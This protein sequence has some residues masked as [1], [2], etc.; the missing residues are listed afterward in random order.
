MLTHK[1]EQNLKTAA[2]IEE[3]RWKL[4]AMLQ[5]RTH[6]TDSITYLLVLLFMSRV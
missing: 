3:G 4:T 5:Y 2:K 1:D 6:D